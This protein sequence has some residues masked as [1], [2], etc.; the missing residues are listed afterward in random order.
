MPDDRVSQFTEIL[1]SAAPEGSAADRLLPIVYDDLHALAERYLRGES[2][3]HTL[4]P[5]ALVHEAYMKLVDQTRVQWQGRTHFLAVGAQAMR[6]ILVDH[7]RRRGAARRGG[8]HQRIAVD[9]QLL[10]AGRRDEDL[11][12]LDGALEKLAALDPAQARM[13]ELRLFPG[14]RLDPA[15]AARH[16]RGQ[17]A[18]H[19]DLSRQPAGR[20]P[21]AGRVARAA[22][23]GGHPHL[24]SPGGDFTG[25]VHAA[26]AA[27]AA[28]RAAGRPPRGRGVLRGGGRRL[29]ALGGDRHGHAVAS[30][31]GHGHC[32]S[33]G[34]HA[35]R[36][37]GPG[38]RAI[39]PG[40]AHDQSADP[41]L[42]HLVRPGRRFRRAGAVGAG[43][44]RFCRRAAVRAIWPF[45]AGPVVA[46]RRRTR[47][48]EQHRTGALSIKSLGI[49]PDAS[50]RH[51]LK[52]KQWHP[53][54]RA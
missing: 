33:R 44:V 8:D 4:Q 9:E 45:V 13:V 29:R 38:R 22:L 52:S 34:A 6:R 28:D 10:A 32:H 35:G 47:G 21:G 30:R 40:G 18:G 16:S 24:R 12:E 51:C 17:A 37:R 19:R 25:H 48:A 2:A 27:G 41:P 26:P 49:S 1:N 36:L 15:G 50:Y 11:L 39:R 20:G 43:R 23:Q 14:S 7:A 42:G 3:G 31:T 53:K 54:S 46:G 5:T